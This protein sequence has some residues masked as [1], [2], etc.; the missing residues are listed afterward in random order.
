MPKDASSVPKLGDGE[1]PKKKAGGDKMYKTQPSGNKGMGRKAGKNDGDA[2]KKK[3]QP[4]T[5]GT[6]RKDD[7]STP[8]SEVRAAPPP[9][10]PMATVTVADCLA[11]V[12]FDELPNPIAWERQARRELHADYKT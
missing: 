4:A 5:G 12:R 11:R 6:P 9:R 8:L 7:P 3:K 10:A 1:A 2:P